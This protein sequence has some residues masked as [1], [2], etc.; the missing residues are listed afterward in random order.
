MTILQFYKDE[1]KMLLK[2]FIKEFDMH[3]Q[4]KKYVTE[5][6]NLFDIM[7]GIDSNVQF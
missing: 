7:N 4:H 2:K 1:I 6:F 3:N 5:T